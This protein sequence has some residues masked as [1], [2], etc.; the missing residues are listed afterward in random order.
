M[1]NKLIPYLLS[2]AML[3][4]TLNASAYYYYYPVYTQPIYTT[5]IVYTDPAATC[6]GA[7]LGTLCGLGL[8]ALLAS[9]FYTFDHTCWL[10]FSND[11]LVQWGRP[12]DWK[13]EADHVQ[14]VRY[15]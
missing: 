7:A 1:N 6:A 14:E 9:D 2:G 13:K 5:P 4:A 8:G 10:Y 3:V 15:R 12:E 11:I